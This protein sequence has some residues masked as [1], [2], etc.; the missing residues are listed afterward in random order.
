[1]AALLLLLRA[2]FSPAGEN[3][4][5]KWIGLSCC[6]RPMTLPCN[7]R[8]SPVNAQLAEVQLYRRLDA[9]VKTRRQTPGR[10]RWSGSGRA[11]AD[12]PA[13]RRTGKR[14]CAPGAPPGRGLAR[15]RARL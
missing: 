9:P 4:A 8:L 15:A 14:R 6:R 5:R 10:L 11:A 7:D 12:P 13:R 1:M 2:R 3:L